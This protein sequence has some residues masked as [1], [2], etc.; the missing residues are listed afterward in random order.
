MEPTLRLD[1]LAKPVH[2]SSL[3]SLF[4]NLRDFLAERPVKVRGGAPEVFASQGFGGGLGE[5]LKE[6]FH[7]GPRGRVNS[8]LLVQWEDET[9]F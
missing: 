8:A 9:G 4:S 7:S 6:F 2:G 1:R 3:K 5:N